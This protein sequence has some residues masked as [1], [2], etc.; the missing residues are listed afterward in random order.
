MALLE[1]TNTLLDFDLLQNSVSLALSPLS[2]VSSAPS[3]DSSIVPC[4]LGSSDDESNM[5]S[6]VTASLEQIHYNRQLDY[7]NPPSGTDVSLTSS[8][9][10]SPLQDDQFMDFDIDEFASGFEMGV[11]SPQSENSHAESV[12]LPKKADDKTAKQTK[13]GRRRTPRPTSAN[14][15]LP[16]C[17]ICADAASGFHY[18]VNSCEACKRF[19]RRALKRKRN[20]KCRGWSVCVCVCVCVCACGFAFV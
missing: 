20:F 5:T 17:R 2:P 3:S 7:L 15:S 12:V 19:F 11:F 4:G 10:S 14:N 1:A 13:E 18:G 8:S 16:P 9:N 6:L